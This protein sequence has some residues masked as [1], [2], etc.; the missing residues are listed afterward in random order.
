MRELAFLN[1]R[2]SVV[3]GGWV[4]A[5]PWPFSEEAQV[6]RQLKELFSG[7]AEELDK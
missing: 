4:E 6:G 7:A 5:G 2:L 3:L 1:D